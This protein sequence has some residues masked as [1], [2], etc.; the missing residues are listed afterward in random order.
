MPQERPT[1]QHDTSTADGSGV[2]RAEWE[3]YTY[4]GSDFFAADRQPTKA[5]P[6]TTYGLMPEAD[7]SVPG[8]PFGMMSGL[9]RRLQE[10]GVVR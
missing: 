3:R 4:R 10:K 7:D 2:E 6:V 1:H 8:R 5:R 9:R